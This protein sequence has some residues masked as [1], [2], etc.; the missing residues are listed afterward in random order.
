MER[1]G[2]KHFAG[3]WKGIAAGCGTV[4]GTT[5]LLFP[6]AFLIWRGFVPDDMKTVL[7]LASVFIAGLV[8]GGLTSKTGERERL[9]Y[10]LS[11]ATGMTLLLMLMTLAMKDGRL[12]V[13]RLFPCV[14]A[15]TAG[16]LVGSKVKINKKYLRKRGTHRKYNR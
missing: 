14:A 2:N 12:A 13:G 9:L 10:M 7:I 1:K 4:L 5:V 15:G 6:I 3:I 8:T 11:A 16:V